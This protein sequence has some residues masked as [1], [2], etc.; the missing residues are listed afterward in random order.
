MNNIF[1]LDV[2]K[3][4]WESFFSRLRC[5][6]TN[7]LSGYHW[8]KC[9]RHRIPLG[10][11]GYTT[12]VKENRSSLKMETVWSLIV[13]SLEPNIIVH[14]NCS[15]IVCLVNKWDKILITGQQTEQIIDS[16]GYGKTGDK[17]AKVLLSPEQQRHTR[18]IHV[19]G[20]EHSKIQSL[21]LQSPFEFIIQ[22]GREGNKLVVVV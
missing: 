11:P 5:C 8:A 21:P 2:L 17:A 18:Y 19:G 6:H 16:D 9:Q 1:I 14:R 3:K 10:E 13:F 15:V 22:K 12:A 20:R 7:T 4:N